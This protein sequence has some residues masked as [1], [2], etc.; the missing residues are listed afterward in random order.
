M[1]IGFA[2]M[3]AAFHAGRARAGVLLVS[4]EPEY[5]ARLA[6]RLVGKQSVAGAHSG[7]LAGVPV[8]IPALDASF[9]EAL[10]RIPSIA[11]ATGCST[12]V[13]IVPANALGRTALPGDILLASRLSAETRAE[14]IDGEVDLLEAIRL[15]GADAGFFEVPDMGRAGGAGRAPRVLL[16]GARTSVDRRGTGGTR[17]RESAGVVAIDEWGAPA[18][19][20][21]AA[22][23]LRWAIVEPLIARDGE[24]ADRT[25][26]ERS[27]ANV[28]RLVLSYLK[29]LSATEPAPAITAAGRPAKGRIGLRE[30][31]D[32]SSPVVGDFARGMRYQLLESTADESWRRILLPDGRTG[33]AFATSLERE[34]MRVYDFA[35]SD[36]IR[37]LFAREYDV[38][39]HEVTAGLIARAVCAPGDSRLTNPQT[40]RSIPLCAG[41]ESLAVDL[42]TVTVYF[43]PK[44][45]AFFAAGRSE[46]EPF[47][48]R[49][50]HSLTEMERVTTVALRFTGEEIAA[51]PRDLRRE[52]FLA[53]WPTNELEAAA[54]GHRDR[55]VRERAE[56]LLAARRP[57]GAASTREAR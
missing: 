24:A 7:T 23:G 10:A 45:S 51:V 28:E 40:Y 55:S 31:P 25:M 2:F 32:P 35:G 50:V 30:I 26:V 39:P 8:A 52:E 34:P 21:L 1:A 44:S 48:A 42:D 37:V 13:A 43:G 27:H 49:L 18:A 16:G 54:A 36:E 14:P 57:A 3:M 46:W 53:F 38:D 56:G 41:I 9:Q 47:L 22:S 17:G 29:A 4:S 12:V 33:W 20:A 19:T 6:D 5:L 15:A 11:A